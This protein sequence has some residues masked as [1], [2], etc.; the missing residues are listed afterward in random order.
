MAWVW[1][2]VLL[3]TAVL[4]RADAGPLPTTCYQGNNVVFDDT[5]GALC[6]GGA[7]S[8]S[9]RAQVDWAAGGELL[10]F[11]VRVDNADQCVSNYG[12]L[13]SSK[14][15]CTATGFVSDEQTT[16]TVTFAAFYHGGS[17]AVASWTYQGAGLTCDQMARSPVLYDGA[18]VSQS[19]QLVIGVPVLGTLTMLAAEP[20]PLSASRIECPLASLR[21]VCTTGCA[22]TP[23]EWARDHSRD[24]DTW[25]R[26][27]LP[28]TICGLH[29]VEWIGRTRSTRPF[30]AQVADVLAEWVATTLNTANF[31]CAATAVPGSAAADQAVDDAWSSVHDLLVKSTS[32]SRDCMD[33][34]HEWTHDTAVLRRYNAGGYANVSGP[35]SC[36]QR[37]C[38]ARFDAKYDAADDAP[39]INP[40]AFHD[41]AP[42]A[43]G[44]H[45]PQHWGALTFIFFSVM[46]ALGCCVVVLVA[47]LG[48]LCLFSPM[49]GPRG[50]R[51]MGDEMPDFGAAPLTAVHHARSDIGH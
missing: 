33:D 38:A 26:S 40:A 30:D 36:A 2:A 16:L 4:V 28:D 25:Q 20:L 11:D 5:S 48:G 29:P 14:A 43:E 1:C 8:V 10:T 23:D 50:F 13:L 49:V 34:T 21:C 35:C 15:S 22:Y 6:A 24:A 42:A 3:A 45:L 9:W 46:L 39:F 41:D 7:C 37:E 44:E 51:F 12:Q 18:L 31:H 32:P 19:F 47:I 17:S 27:L